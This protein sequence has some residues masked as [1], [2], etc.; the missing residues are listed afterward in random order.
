MT[1]EDVRPLIHDAY[2][3]QPSDAPE[4]R[5]HVAS[6]EACRSFAADLES[7]SSAFRSLPPSPLPS[8]ALDAVWQRTTR[9]RHAAFASKWRLAA[10]AAF[11]SVLSAAA[12]Y[13]AL[14]PAP[15]PKPSAVEIARA[16]AKAELV[17]GYT[18]RALGAARAAAADRVVASKISPAVRGGAGLHPTRRP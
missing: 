1:C 9:S 17:L 8:D 16:E 7:L 14:A 13:V 3:G 15:P 6:C 11:V 12:L 18:A 2:D 10:A 4:F 5:S